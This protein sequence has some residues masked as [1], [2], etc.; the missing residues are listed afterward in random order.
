MFVNHVEV[1]R[2]AF[3]RINDPDF[4]LDY[5]KP[6]RQNVLLTYTYYFAFWGSAFVDFYFNLKN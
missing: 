1:L 2:I 4:T 5:L 6:K 3:V